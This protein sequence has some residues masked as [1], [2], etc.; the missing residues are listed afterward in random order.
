MS[1]LTDL[2]GPIFVRPGALIAGTWAAMQ[3][4]GHNGYL[5]SCK[6]IVTAAKTIAHRIR[7]EIPEL[8]V[9]G[10]PPASVVA[11]AAGP[12][13]RNLNVLEVGDKMSKRGWHLNAISNPA[14][15]HIAVTVR[16][17]S[18]LFWGLG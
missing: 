10:N 6:A 16:S 4:M 8:R 12:G 7:T 5:E 1:N 17:S 11:F 13:E 3:Y 18:L 14:A 9:L 2:S 15:V